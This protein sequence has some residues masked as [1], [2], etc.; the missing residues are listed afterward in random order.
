MAATFLAGCVANSTHNRLAMV[1]DPGT[2]LAFGS[3]IEK[4]MLV[5]SS[6]YSNKK[7]KVRIRN[8]SG[9]LAFDMQGFKSRLERAYATKGYEPT[10]SD[11]FRLLIDVNVMYS[12]QIQRD[13][14]SEFG[15]LGAAAGG[16]A[17]AASRGTNVAT[18]G[19]VVAGAT[20]GTILGSFVTE[21]TYIIVARV[22]FGEIKNTIKSKKTVTFSGSVRLKDVDEEEEDKDRIKQRGFR[23]RYSTGLSVFAGGTNTP[24]GAIAS[25]VRDRIIRI[26]SDFI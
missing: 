17:G 4:N 15:F 20:L 3:V 25:E 2:G 1:R 12:G 19:G 10:E 23:E 8:T 11:D 5:D 21:D 22:T 7:M 6:F 18:A 24:Q 9:D 14:S 26:V 16:V 13:M